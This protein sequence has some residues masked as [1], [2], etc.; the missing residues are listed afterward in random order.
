M[1]ITSTILETKFR[2]KTED[3]LCRTSNIVRLFRVF[4]ISSL[5]ANKHFEKL[6]Y[7]RS[8]DFLALEPLIYTPFRSPIPGVARAQWAVTDTAEE[9]RMP[10]RIRRRTGRKRN[11]PR[12]QLFVP[13]HSTHLYI[14]VISIEAYH[15]FRFI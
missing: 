9:R 15:P 10:F 8:R 13:R 11:R 4:E 7:L 3:K 5:E 1:L 2:I 14:F 6:V 12:R